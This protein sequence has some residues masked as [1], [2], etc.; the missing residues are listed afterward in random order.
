MFYLVLKLRMSGG[1]T[2]V[3]SSVETAYILEDYSFF[4]VLKLRMSGRITAVF[5]SV[6]AAYV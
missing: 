1:T 5:F 2:A 6:E 4:C 3:L